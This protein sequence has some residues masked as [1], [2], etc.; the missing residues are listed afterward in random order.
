MN[1]L[2]MFEDFDDVYQP[3]VDNTTTQPKIGD[4]NIPHVNHDNLG[5]VNIQ[6][7]GEGFIKNAILTDIK[8]VLSKYQGERH[9]FIDGNEI[10]PY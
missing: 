7:T 2:K 10:N 4:N 6:V 9:L 1:K 5:I 8:K 3:T